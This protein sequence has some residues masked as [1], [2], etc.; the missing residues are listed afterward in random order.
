LFEKSQEALRLYVR[1]DDLRTEVDG[2][3]RE[4]A[5]RDE[6]MAQ[7]KEELAKLEEELAHKDELF[8]QTKDEL[9]SDATDSYATGFEDSMAQVACVHPEVDLSQK[10]LN[11]TIADG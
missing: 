5:S 2:L 6:E 3:K 10:G 1:N 11:K 7:Q 9:T 4:L 8:Q